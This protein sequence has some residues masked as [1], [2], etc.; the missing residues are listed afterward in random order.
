MRIA[1]TARSNGR[2]QVLMNTLL[3]FMA[4]APASLAISGWLVRL[5]P[6][7][8]ALPLSLVIGFSIGYLGAQN[9]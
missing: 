3:I 9:L 6:I 5:I 7:A 8:V 1:E 4:G 2:V